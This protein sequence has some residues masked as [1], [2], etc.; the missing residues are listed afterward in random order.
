MIPWMSVREIG[1]VEELLLSIIRHNKKL[2]ILEWG[3][4]GSTKHFSEFLLKQKI[5]F[6]WYSIEYNRK[7]YEKVVSMQLKNVNV[8]LFDVGNNSLKQRYTNMDNYVNFPSTLGILFDAIL[9]DGRKR[10]KCL[11]NAYNLVK[12]DGIVML[13]DANRKYYHCALKQYNK[14]C[15]C[16]TLWVGKKA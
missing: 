14:V 4:G 1:K 3:S 6:Y 9:I 5:D 11:N 2:H 8:C 7:W 13:H 15:L 10:R 16:D 12:N